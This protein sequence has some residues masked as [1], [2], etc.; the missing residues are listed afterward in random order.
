MN[1]VTV[2]QR[3]A[4]PERREIMISPLFCPHPPASPADSSIVALSSATDHVEIKVLKSHREEPEER[5]T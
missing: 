5:R 3:V 4:R 1:L 2:H